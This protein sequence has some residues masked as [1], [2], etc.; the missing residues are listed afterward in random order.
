[1]QMEDRMPNHWSAGKRAGLDPN[2]LVAGVLDS[3]SG[4]F[5]PDQGI[6]PWD[7]FKSGRMGSFCSVP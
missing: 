5:K 4:Q 7:S 2:F 3:W 1:M 6:E